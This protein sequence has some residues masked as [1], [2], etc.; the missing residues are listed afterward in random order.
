[1]KILKDKNKMIIMPWKDGCDNTLQQCTSIL[2]ALETCILCGQSE[3]N[4]L[5]EL[6][7]EDKKLLKWIL[8]EGIVKSIFGELAYDHKWVIRQD[9]IDLLK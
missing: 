4:I 9:I 2:K 3:Y 6:T 5:D 7:S 8:E 1:M